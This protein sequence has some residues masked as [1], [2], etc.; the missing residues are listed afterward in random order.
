MAVDVAAPLG[1]KISGIL[2]SVGDRVSRE[3]DLMILEA[4]KMEIPICAPVDGK[5]VAIKVAKGAAVEPDDLLLI[6]D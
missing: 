2:C 1:G 4:M 6:I 5:V 3:D